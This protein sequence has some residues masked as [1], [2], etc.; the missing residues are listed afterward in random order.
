[1]LF[2]FAICLGFKTDAPNSYVCVIWLLVYHRIIM[3]FLSHS[4]LLRVSNPKTWMFCHGSALIFFL[5]AVTGPVPTRCLLTITG[6]EG[7]EVLEGNADPY[8]TVA[9]GDMEAR[10]GFPSNRK[11]K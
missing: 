9:V 10:P 6:V 1:M 2:F 7:L 3:A 4:L 5:Q 8:V 11:C